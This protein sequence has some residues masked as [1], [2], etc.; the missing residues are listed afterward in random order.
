MS[1][2]DEMDFDDDEIEAMQEDDEDA[3]TPEEVFSMVMLNPK[4]LT[5]VSAELQDKE[6]DSVELA[7]IM[8]QITGYIKDRLKDPEGNQFGDQI[9][10][11]MSQ[12]SVSLLGRI[13]GLRTTAFLMANPMTRDAIIYAM[14][15]SFLLLKWVQE[16]DI[17]INTIEEH[18]SQEEI[19]SIYRKAEANSAATMGA[20]M[21]LDPQDI[22]RKMYDEGQ[23]TKDDFANLFDDD[24]E[25]DDEGSTN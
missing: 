6:G 3:L 21:G 9:M 10:P 23:I 14:C 7:D 1:D 5:K 8:I 24:G 4:K 22:L 18:I 2:F 20:L 11:L 13:M 12:A 15:S 16:N 25:K 19:D 17:V